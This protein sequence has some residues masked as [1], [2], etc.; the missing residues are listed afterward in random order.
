M[1]DRAQLLARGRLDGNENVRRPAAVKPAHHGVGR[2]R[3]AGLLERVGEHGGGD[4]LAVDQHPVTIEMITGPPD[5][6]RMTRSSP[7]FLGG[8]RES[9]YCFA[10]QCKERRV[11]GASYAQN[12]ISSVD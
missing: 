5:V 8:L 12:Q 3:D 2:Y 4:R 10:A 7:G 1:R 11:F 6:G 9:R